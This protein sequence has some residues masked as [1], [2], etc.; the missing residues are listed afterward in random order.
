MDERTLL[1]AGVAICAGIITYLS[2]SQ[3]QKDVIFRRLTLRGRRASSATTP[4]RSL[5]PDKKDPSNA[6]PK[7]SEYV[8]T[9]PPLLRENLEQVAASLPDDQCEAMG[10]LSFDE[11]N[12]SKSVLGWEEDFRKADPKKY[13]YT[14]MKVQEVRGLGDFPD[15]STL[16]GVPMPEPYPEHDVDKALPRPYR[17][18][19]WAY[20]QTMSLTKL[21][22]NWWLEVESTYKE[23][24][25]QRKGL[26][27]EHGEAVLQW[28]PG[29]EL[30]CKELME[31]VLQFLCARY[32]Q[33]FELH[34]DKRTFENKILGT[35]QDVKAKHPLLVLLD[36]VPED[37]AITLRNPETGYYYFRAG[38][39]CSA[40]G[41]NVGTKIGMN[42]DQIHAPIPDYKEKMQFSMDRFF[43][44]MPA[45]KPIQRGS[46]GLEIDQPLYMPPG[47]PHEKY[48]DFQMPDLERDRVHLRVDWQTLRRLPLSG[49]I[50]F[51]FKALFTPLTEFRDEP[52]IPSLI[53]KIMKDGKE[54]LMKYKNTW[55][56][57]HEVLPALREYEAEQ[58]AKGIVEKDWQHHTLDESPYFPG[59]REK[60]ERKQ[61]FAPKDC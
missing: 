31:M 25:A 20:H 7:S 40:L 57:E 2:L 22:P 24:I 1:W 12:W 9:F 42:L 35:K 21:E 27:A 32:P 16:S 6:P 29:S 8:N 49:G 50:V 53:L 45:G 52:Y 41:W 23:R 58:L 54:N 36:N 39:I 13:V 56:V 3:R 34:S 18:F 26:Y 48:R 11:A 43:T 46:W 30:A 4:P 55:H 60:W 51:N 37:F 61:G 5:S 10:D 15:Y 19:R 47:D 14:G 33:H 28:L 44:K 17:P 59:W 38:M